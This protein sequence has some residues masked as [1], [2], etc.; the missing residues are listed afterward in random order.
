M[1]TVR[2]VEENSVLSGLSVV[3]APERCDEGKRLLKEWR[4]AYDESVKKGGD[5][6]QVVLSKGF[7]PYLKHARVCAACTEYDVVRYSYRRI[8]V[9]ERK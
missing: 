3:V 1:A 7:T 5:A 4:T 9:E 8:R 6:W 2:V